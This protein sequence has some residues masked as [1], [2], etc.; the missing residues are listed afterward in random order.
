MPIRP[1]PPCRRPPCA[2]SETATTESESAPPSIPID[3]LLDILAR[4]DVATVV[5]CAAT[6][7]PIRRAIVG[8][9]F[10]GA[11]AALRAGGGGGFDPSLLLGFTY[12]HREDSDDPVRVVQSQSPTQNLLRFDASLLETFYPVAVR[13]GLVVLRPRVK[14]GQLPPSGAP[15]LRVC[16]S[17][18]GDMVRLPPAAI[19]DDEYP[20]ALLT[21]GDAGRSFEL[22]VTDG[23]LQAQTFSSKECRWGAAVDIHVVRPRHIDILGSRSHP[24]VLGAGTVVHWLC[25]SYRGIMVLDMGTAQATQMEL[26]PGY[27]GRV[28]HT[29]DLH[30]GL[31]LATSQDGRLGLLVSEILDISMW[32]LEK[33]PSSSSAAAAR[34]TWTRQVVVRRQTICREAGAGPSYSV[35]FMGF[36]ERSGAVVLQI[37]GVGLVRL[38]LGTKEAIVLDRDFFKH[39]HGC[40][41]H[42]RLCLHETDLSSL[43]QVMKP[44]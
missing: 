41:Y 37:D 17:L 24:V 19:M 7:K 25:E 35:K 2:G 12:A 18:T 33:G 44:F 10:R 14:R 36:G 11:I 22:L 6:S 16:N 15:E 5:R 38:N 31:L 23:R 42:V 3:L 13:G 27:L 34:W 20:P 9:G 21:V 4:T 40:P 32:T 30:S 39:G 43:L 8:P 1:A 28:R 26:P 29:Q